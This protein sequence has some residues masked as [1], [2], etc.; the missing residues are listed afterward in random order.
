MLKW[1]LP[2]ETNFFSF[3]E[4]HAKIIVEISNEFFQLVE[5]ASFTPEKMANITSLEHQADQI[6]HQCVEALHKT[7]IT[8]FERHDIYRL[9][10][11]MDDIVDLVEE[12]TARMS[13][14]KLA[15]GTDELKILAQLL[16]KATLVLQKEIKGLANQKNGEEMEKAYSEIKQIERQ[17]DMVVREALGLLFNTGTDAIAI[18]KWKEIYEKIEEAIDCCQNVSNIIEGV[19]LES[20]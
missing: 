15:A 17:A 19:I 6:T 16:Y 9:I 8:P 18:I 7:F 3:F 5:S 2:K 12:L 13:V 4:N 1:L 20:T 11:R 10:S 14:Y